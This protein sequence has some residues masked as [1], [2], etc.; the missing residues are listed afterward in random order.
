MS[1]KSRTSHVATVTAPLWSIKALAMSARSS[2][3]SSAQGSRRGTPRA[4]ELVRGDDEVSCGRG[5]WAGAGGG[6]R[7]NGLPTH[8][9]GTL[10]SSTCVLR[11]LMCGQR[12]ACASARRTFPEPPGADV[13]PVATAVCGRRQGAARKRV[14]GLQEVPVAQALPRAAGA[15]ARAC[16]SDPPVCC[17]RVA[18]LASGAP[19]RDHAGDS[20]RGIPA[21]RTLAR[22]FRAGR[23]RGTRGHGMGMAGA[24]RRGRRHLPHA[25]RV[26]ARL[27]RR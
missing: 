3:R 9:R 20:V 21:A 18:V 19:A 26:H 5:R 25:R 6:S 24:L 13:P 12:A 1:P 11:A 2:A 16:L 22:A 17:H 27:R 7:A 14:P 15:R 23:A 8:S 4:E 10:S